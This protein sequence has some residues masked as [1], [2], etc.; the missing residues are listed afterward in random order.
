MKAAF[1][2]D[3]LNI[4]PG[5]LIRE[6]AARLPRMALAAVRGNA[7]RYCRSY[8][9]MYYHPNEVPGSVTE[10]INALEAKWLSKRQ[11]AG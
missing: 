10:R 6:T 1:K 4:E 5:H 9:I 3:F 2:T 7:I 11:S 8:V